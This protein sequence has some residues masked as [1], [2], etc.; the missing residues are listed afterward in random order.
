MPAEDGRTCSLS[1]G[2]RTLS[3][4]VVSRLLKLHPATHSTS[5]NYDTLLVVPWQGV[6]LRCI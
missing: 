2:P 4:V 5:T 1:G 6:I 3:A